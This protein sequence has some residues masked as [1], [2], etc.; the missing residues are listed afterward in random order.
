MPEP[1]KRLLPRAQRRAQIIDAAKRSFA[2][3][4]FAATSMVD[5]A[6]ESGVTK[7]IIYRHFATKA[8]LYRSVLDAVS[9]ELNTAVA[10][11]GPWPAA[12]TAIVEF[13]HRDPDGFA[14]LFQHAAREPDF[15]DYTD[16]ASAATLA[17][18]REELNAYLPDRTRRE[19]AARLLPRLVIQVVLT[20]LDSGQPGGVASTTATVRELTGAAV[21]AIAGH[22]VG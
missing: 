11:A 21:R 13:A 12:A 4:G 18:A 3:N 16:A 15:Q 22:E 8:D 7:M 19:W 5:L 10:A 1:T 20:W 14:L 17:T 9:D 6:D 2:R